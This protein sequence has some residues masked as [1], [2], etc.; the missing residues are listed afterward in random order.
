MA[1]VHKEMGEDSGGGGS[2]DGTTSDSILAF[3]ALSTRKR[4]NVT[5]ENAAVAVKVFAFDLLMIGGA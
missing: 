3:Q 1:V 4:K 5:E 2:G